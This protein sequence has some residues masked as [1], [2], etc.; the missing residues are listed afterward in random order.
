MPPTTAGKIFSGEKPTSYHCGSADKQIPA[1]A[2]AEDAVP[3]DGGITYAK[4][5]QQLLSNGQ[6]WE[7]PKFKA[8]DESLFYSKKP[9]KPFAW[10]RPHEITQD[11][12]LFVGG[13]N[14]NDISQGMLGDCWLLASVVLLCRDDCLVHQVVP[15]GQSFAQGDY[16]GAFRFRFWQYG[17]WE[18]VIVDDRLPT[19]NNRLVF[20]H[21]A[22]T[23]EFWSALLEKAYA[24][25]CGTYEAL[26]GGQ[27]SEAME[28]FTGGVTESWEL[29]KLPEE[30]KDFHRI[31]VRAEERLSLMCASV[32]NKGHAGEGKTDNGLVTNHAYS[33]TDSRKVQSSGQQLQLVRLRNPWGNDCEWKGA[34]SDGSN[35]WNQLSSE[36][37]KD[38]GLVCD[39]DGEFWMDFHDFSTNF[40]KIEICM[41]GPDSAV[42]DVKKARGWASEVQQGSWTKNVSAGGCRN[43]PDKFHINPQFRITLEDPDDDDDVDGCTIV[44]A[45][46]QKGR[47]ELRRVGVQNLTIGFAVYK[48]DEGDYEEYVENDRLNN[49][50]FL[51][52]KSAARSPN[53]VNG[54]EVTG[55]F[56]L[57]TGQYVVVPSTYKP[58][59]EG[60]FVL[61]MFSEKA[62]KTEVIDTRT[63]IEVKETVFTDDEKKAFDA[64]FKPCFDKVAGEDQHIDAFELRKVANAA[65]KEELGGRECSLEACRSMVSKVDRDRNGAMDYEEFRTLWKCVLEWRKHFNNYDADNSGDMS[66]TELR[67]A[68]AKLGFKLGTPALSSIVLRYANKEGKVNV[69]DF[70]QICCR[71]SST[72]ESYLSYQGK[73]FSLDDYIMSA[74]YT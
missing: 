51:Y 55:R 47:R 12:Q 1:N 65:F 35:E 48:L 37:K 64:K 27:T 56:T 29:Q 41:L 69:D 33:I 50:F 46:L 73:S 32:Q 43:F 44:I 59:E 42:D 39:D 3:S 66:A 67:D 74:I 31:M 23:N 17:R 58:G 20:L 36:Q 9:P 13:A 61:R 54:R 57:P 6:L 71:I 11:P 40:T 2:R 52:H 7:D 18:E 16:C 53:F 72:F 10:K 26:K 62:Q 60:E 8:V 68:L 70:I 45:L 38:I 34:W 19:Y 25:L 21:S 24:K 22:T 15:E 63:Q 49:D 30:I 28:D 4:L 14:R 5:K